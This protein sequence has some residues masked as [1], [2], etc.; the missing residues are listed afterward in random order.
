MRRVEL[1]YDIAGLT[2]LEGDTLV[3]RDT[4]GRTSLYL[5]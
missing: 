4:A 3:V 5:L 1:E 2:V